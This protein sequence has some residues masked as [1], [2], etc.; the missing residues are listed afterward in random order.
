MDDGAGRS[1]SVRMAVEAEAGE[2][3]HTELFFQN[4]LRVIVLKSLVVDAAF[5]AAGS[6][7]QGNFSGFEELR[8]AREQSFA[9]ME[10]LQLI[11]KGFFRLRAG[12]L[13]ALKFAGGKIDKGHADDVGDSI[14][15]NRR[16]K[17]IFLGFEHRA[18]G[19]CAGSDDADD[20]AAD[21]FLAGAGLFHL[22]SDGDLE[23]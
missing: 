2:F 8:R 1:E 21:E 10:E 20:F 6:I 22:I 23:A 14:L 13:G 12:K 18:I 19:G 3:G 5:D 11:A 16:E 15:K 17:I 4:A 7:E 9:G